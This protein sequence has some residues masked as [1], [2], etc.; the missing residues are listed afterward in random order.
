MVVKS[1][2]E[3]RHVEDLRGVFEVLRQHKLCLNAKKCTFGVGAG[4]FLGYLITNRGIE[5]NLNQI[6]AVNHLKPSSNPKEVQSLLRRLDFTRQI[7][8]WGT[9]L[10]SFDIR[11]RPQ[12]SIKGQ[13][14]ADFVV[15]FSPKDDRKIIYLVENCPWKVF[16]DGASS[17]MG[18][19]ARIVIITPEG[20]HLE[21]SFRLGFKASNNEA[22]YEALLAGLRTVLCL[23]AQ[24][25]EIYS[26]SRLVVYQIQG[27]I[28]AQDSWMKAYLRAAK[29]IINKFE[30][31]KVAQVN[32]AQNRHTDSL[33]TLASSMTE[34]IPQL[35]KVKLIREP[36]IGMG[37][38]CITAEINVAVISTTRLCWMDSIIDFLAE[39]R[40]SDDEKEA[41]KIRRVASRYWLSAD[42]KLYRRGALVSTPSD[43]SRILVAADVERCSGICNHRFVLVAVDYFMKWAEADALANI[44]DV[45][46]K[47]FVL[48]NIVTRFGSNGQA[49]ATNK[50]IL[51]ELKRRLDWAK[52]RWAEELPNVLWAYR[53]TPRRSTGETPFSLTYGAKAV[54]PAE[55]NLCSARVA[56]FDLIQ[57]DGLMLERL[58]WLEECREAATIRL[59]EYQQ[60]LAQRYN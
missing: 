31:M 56:G 38:S 55:V 53:T 25:V 15:E 30:T 50:T 10:G 48:K 45:D 26:N 3:A 47:K 11:Y 20:I 57:N 42:H 49:E 32:R 19:R 44:R 4:K 13:V 29:Q 12:S 33:A 52:G 1:K 8:K 17:V 22:V 43:D 6:E 28:E 39:D 27:S 21:H 16:V 23:G 2:Q 40:V 5:A 35:I 18:A 9:R 46:I 59:V 58:D 60:K 14:L 51:N 54:I 24:D 36:S 37:D 41:K 7:A 34:E